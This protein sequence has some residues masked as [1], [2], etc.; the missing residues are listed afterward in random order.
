M[1][2][3]RVS[4]SALR[5]FS[6][7]ARQGSLSRAADHLCISASAV[8]HQMKLLEQ[9]LGVKLFARRAHGVKLTDAGVKLASHATAAMLQLENGLQK[10]TGKGYEQLT[11]AAIPAFAQLW[12]VPRLKGFYEQFPHFELTLIEQ[13]NLIDFVHQ[14]VDLH[15]HFGSGEFAGLKSRLLMKESAAPVCAPELLKTGADEVLMGA[16]TRKLTYQ[17]F[18]EDRPGGLTWKGWFNHARLEP[19]HPQSETRFSHITPLITAAR[20]GLGMALGWQQLIQP[21]LVD[22]SLISLSKIWVPLKYGYY[23][24]APEENF[25]RPQVKQFLSWIYQQC[26]DITE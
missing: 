3:S 21:M 22:K 5:T 18:D 24:V 11:I 8:S 25:E 10:T 13:D 12:L 15:L 20:N 17:G 16:N 1:L 2:L 19:H 4:L 26:P 23:A 6:E 9:Q 14:P 7:V